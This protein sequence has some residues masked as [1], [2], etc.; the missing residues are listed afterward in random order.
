MHFKLLDN[1]PTMQGVNENRGYNTLMAIPILGLDIGG[2]NLKAAHTSGV[3]RTIPFALWK[4]PEGL[5]AE[6]ARLRAGMPPHDFLAITMTG[7]LCDCF[8]TRRAG[9]AAILQS[10]LA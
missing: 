9:V 4:H 6:L 5:A 10:A 7:E 3:A 1:T 2:A 8:P